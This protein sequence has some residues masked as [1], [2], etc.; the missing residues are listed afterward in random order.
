MPYLSLRLGLNGRLPGHDANLSQT[1]AEEQ[2]EALQSIH[3]EVTAWLPIETRIYK[4]NFEEVKVLGKGMFGVVYQ[5]RHVD[6]IHYAIKKLKMSSWDQG[7]IN[8]VLSEAHTLAELNHE[9]ITR[10]YN[11]WV[12]PITRSEQDTMAVGCRSPASSSTAGATSEPTT[13]DGNPRIDRQQHGPECPVD[14]HFSSDG[15]P[16]S[17]AL[18]DLWLYIQMQYCSGKTLREWLHERSEVDVRISL[19]V[20][21]QIARGVE[22]VHGKAMIQ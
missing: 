14:Q 13:V 18:P 12:E 1:D 21:S 16:S 20:F 3:S 5:C 4:N 15:T 7:N 10:L 2:M 6:G 9:N 17:K 19:Q 11:W 22:Y 8:T